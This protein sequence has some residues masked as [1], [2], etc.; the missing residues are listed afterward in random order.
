MTA[1][2]TSTH[3]PPCSLSPSLLK[4]SNPRTPQTKQHPA[5]RALLESVRPPRRHRRHLRQRARP[6][7]HRQQR[8]P[9]SH[10]LPPPPQSHLSHLL[11]DNL[12][13]PHSQSEVFSSMT[14]SIK[15]SASRLGR[16]AQ[17]GNKVAV[18]KLAGIVIG[19]VVVLWWGLSFLFRSRKA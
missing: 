6:A 1:S 7:R 16:M 9:P 8:M 2:S 10:S 18:L 3:S 11:S 4:P 17:Q 12:P 13:L 19:V 14:S 5:L 15:G